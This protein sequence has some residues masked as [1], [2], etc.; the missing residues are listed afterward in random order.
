MAL[1]KKYIKWDKYKVHDTF[2]KHPNTDKLETK[3][4]W[5]TFTELEFTDNIS[6]LGIVEYD[7]DNIDTIKLAAYRN[8]TK[9]KKYNFEIV[10]NHIL[11]HDYW[12]M[13][14]IEEL[15]LTKD[16]YLSK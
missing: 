7:S 4:D 3:D 6:Y 13:Y 9:L 2:Y 14:R 16:E 12:H 11:F 8:K 15:W 5:I 1:V 10:L